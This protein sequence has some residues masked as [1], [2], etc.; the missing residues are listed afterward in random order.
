M[1]QALRRGT[2]LLCGLALYGVSTALLVRAEL[3]ADPWTVFAQGIART[4][5]VSLG[6]VVL[7]V[8]AVVFGL[9]LPLRQRPG[10]GTLANAVLVGPVLDQALKVIPA[11]QTLPGRLCLLGLGT[12]G[13]AVATGL[14]IGAGLGPGPRDGLMTGLARLGVPVLLARTGIEF[15]VLAGGGLLGGTIGIGT[16]VYALGIGPLVAFFL[17]RLAVRPDRP[18]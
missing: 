10:V 9:W 14:Y 6:V 4:T 3:G 5:Q 11:P 8:S 7:L 13:V 1:D 17:P 2:R 16:A 15:S 18:S 12:V